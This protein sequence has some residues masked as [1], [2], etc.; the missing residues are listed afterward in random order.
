MKP[1]SLDSEL[2]TRGVEDIITREE[3]EGRLKQKKPLRVKLGIDLTSPDLHL[4]HASALWKIRTLQDAGHKAV[5]ILGGATTQIGDPTGK[6]EA[7]RAITSTEIKTNTKKIR[8]QVEM[9][10][11]TDKRSYELRNNAEWFSKMKALDFLR[12]TSLVTHARLVE[13]DMF[14]ERI[15]SGKEIA[16]SEVL[17][18]ILQGYDSVAIKSDLTVIGSDQLFNEHIGR[19]MQEKFSQ[20]PQSLVTLKILPGLGGGEK[21]SKSLGNYIGLLDSP[22]DKFGKAMRVLDELIASYLEVYTDVPLEVVKKI[23]SD[24][25]GGMNPM[26]AKLFLARSLVSRYHGARVAA[27]TQEDFLATFSLGEIPR[28]MPEVALREGIWHP[29][30][31]LVAAGLARSKSEARRLIIQGALDIDGHTVKP[32][33]KEIEVK[34]AMVIRAGK[35]RFV[36][37]R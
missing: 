13:R 24:L 21:M 7:R 33:E 34:K 28:D 11:Q 18:P 19:M 1:V 31:L 14:Q 27:A 20:R 5:I 36:R 37:V 8:K 6:T 3:L 17:Y 23:I 22:K 2:F 26:E 16:M 30:D 15:T 25:A 10:L 4:G 12:L 9:I 29:A 32:E 35:R